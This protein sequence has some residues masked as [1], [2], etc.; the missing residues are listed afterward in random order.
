MKGLFRDGICLWKREKN[1]HFR[2][3]FGPYLARDDKTQNKNI[4]FPQSFS[5]AHIFLIYAP[6]PLYLPGSLILYSFLRFFASCWNEMRVWIYFMLTLSQLC[7]CS[8]NIFFST[9]DKP[10][11]Q[12][13]TYHLNI[14]R[15]SVVGYIKSEYSWVITWNKRWKLTGKAT[16][17][18]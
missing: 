10:K 3:C 8:T 11:Y 4:N 2:S 18:V 14:K 6:G 13:A 9:L 17:V 16:G 5:I 7:L 12:F 1:I 15:K